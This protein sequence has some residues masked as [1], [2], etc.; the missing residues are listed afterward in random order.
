MLWL[1]CH[2]IKL[3][4]W[5][6]CRYSFHCNGSFILSF[7]FSWKDVIFRRKKKL[8][9]QLFFL[10][11]IF[12]ISS[13][14]LPQQTFHYETAFWR[15]K[16]T[17]HPDGGKTGFDSQETKLPS[18]WN[19]SFSKICLG[20]KIN[21]QIN[22]TVINKQANSLYSLIADGQ[23]RSTSLGRDKWLSLIGSNASLQW[24]CKK[25]GFNAKCTLSGRSKTRIGILGNDQT[26]CHEC[27]SRLGFGSEGNYDDRRNTCGNL[28]N[29][30]GKRLSIKTM[31]YILVQW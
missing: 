5:G 11:D 6:H 15:N 2:F 18:Y 29:H 16:E 28:D 24:N 25:E 3:E 8:K 9:F 26:D 21:N 30:K 7:F 17:F 12:A 1:N 4:K 14:F 13:S 19:T 22:F 31:G 23:Y 27:N 20:M 10:K